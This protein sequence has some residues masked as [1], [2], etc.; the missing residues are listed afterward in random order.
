MIYKLVLTFESVSVI[1]QCDHSN[2]SFEGELFCD[3][4]PLY[5]F[6]CANFT[7]GRIFTQ[8]FLAFYQPNN[9]AYI[10]SSAVT[11]HIASLSWFFQFFNSLANSMQFPTCTV[12]DPLKKITDFV[13]QTVARARPDNIFGIL[14]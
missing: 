13:H 14:R 2:E 1:L 5:I 8:K 4:I 7:N 10:S 6:S 3:A 12:A 11:C 9:H